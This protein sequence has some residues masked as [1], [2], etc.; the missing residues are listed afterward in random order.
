M[1]RSGT[2][3]T[4]RMCQRLNPLTRSLAWRRVPSCHLAVM[5]SART[6]C[7]YGS[8]QRP[9]MA[10][11]GGVADRRVRLALASLAC[12]LAG[13]ALLVLTFTVLDGAF[14]WVVVAVAVDVVAMVLGN[15][16]LQPEPKGGPWHWLA[17][18]AFVLPVAL[19]L[20]PLCGLFM[21]LFI[22]PYHGGD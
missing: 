13:V 17:V 19:L 5:R 10:D 14:H 18:T 20:L 15:R 22:F 9:R 4:T 3:S 16:S 21:L 12:S 6:V 8:S 1:L 2:L 7:V 11:S